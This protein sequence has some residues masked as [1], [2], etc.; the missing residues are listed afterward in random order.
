M[1][2]SIQLELPL[3]I[4]ILALMKGVKEVIKLKTLEEVR[5]DANVI[6]TFQRVDS[7]TESGNIRTQRWR[8][9]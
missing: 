9:V 7:N 6:D 1:S 5:I 3:D 2:K 8:E 4:A